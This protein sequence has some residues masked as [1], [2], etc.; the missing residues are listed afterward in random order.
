MPNLFRPSAKAVQRGK[1]DPRDRVVFYQGGRALLFR[2]A[3]LVDPL[4]NATV[5]KKNFVKAK[6]VAPPRLNA[7]GKQAETVAKNNLPLPIAIF[8][9]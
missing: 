9:F 7:F 4:F 6:E 1:F 3:T 2:E 8:T 5:A